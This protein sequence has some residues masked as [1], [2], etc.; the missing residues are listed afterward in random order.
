M[1]EVANLRESTN[2]IF[3]LFVSTYRNHH[4]CIASHKVVKIATMRDSTKIGL[5]LFDDINR[6]NPICIASLKVVKVA[7]YIER[8]NANRIVSICIN[9]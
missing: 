7:S 8:C 9:K 1:R 5:F 6:N 3:F 4:I 2:R